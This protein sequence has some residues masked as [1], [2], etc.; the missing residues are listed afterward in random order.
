MIFMT[1]IT[2][3][4]TKPNEIQWR[5]TF[6]HEPTFSQSPHVEGSSKNLHKNQDDNDNNRDN[7]PNQSEYSLLSWFP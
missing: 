5:E 7:L 3:F 2:R 1:P 6:I 4:H